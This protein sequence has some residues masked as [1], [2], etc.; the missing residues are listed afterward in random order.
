M[1]SFA[2]KPEKK[3]ASKILTTPKGENILKGKLLQLM[4][5]RGLT[6]IAVSR[7]LNLSP[8]T[9]SLWLKGDYNADDKNIVEKVNAFINRESEKDLATMYKSGFIET[10]VAKTIF[11]I[12]RKC[13][14]KNKVGV[15][16]G[17]AGLGK[18]TTVK[19]YAEQNPDAI[20]IEA[21][22][23]YTPKVLFQKLLRKLGMTPSGSIHE[24]HE[25]IID[26]LS[27][28]GRIIIIDE[29]EHLPYKALELIRRIYDKAGVGILLIGMPRLYYNLCGKKGEYEQLYTRALYKVP[30][31]LLSPEDV[32]AIVGQAIPANNGI[33]EVFYDFCKGNTRMLTNLLEN[34]IERAK[35]LN[36]PLTP[37]VIKSVAKLLY[38]EMFRG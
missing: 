29:A 9:L 5:E 23:G 7:A 30:L 6:Q 8:T 31:D 3:S 10:S 1:L 22:L 25:A 34:S 18:T 13:H 36:R 35:V 15:I 14:I 20:L 2:K 21:D 38:V 32:E 11:E 24:M 26:K 37:D 16:Y 33:W 17:G 12:A 4:R 27:D 19:E 28:S